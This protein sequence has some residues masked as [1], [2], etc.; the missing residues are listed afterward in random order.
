MFPLQYAPQ[1]D[2]SLPYL[3]QGTLHSTPGL[4]AQDSIDPSFNLFAL[5]DGT[6]PY[7]PHLGPDYFI[8][9]PAATQP[10]GHL[11]YQIRGVGLKT[12]RKQYPPTKSTMNHKPGTSS[13]IWDASTSSSGGARDSPAM[14]TQQMP[15]P[16]LPP[17]GI[18][19]HSWLPMMNKQPQGPSWLSPPESQEQAQEQAQAP[20]MMPPPM[21]NDEHLPRSMYFEAAT[22]SPPA[23]SQP[24]PSPSPQPPKIPRTRSWYD[25][26]LRMRVKIDPAVMNALEIARDS[27]EGAS[28]VEIKG[29]LNAAVEKVEAKIRAAPDSYIMTMNEFS[30]VNWFQNLGRFDGDRVITMAVV[31]FWESWWGDSAVF[32]LPPGVPVPEG[33]DIKN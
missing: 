23:Q 4:D 17:A 13:P 31:R 14:K 11:L 20:P 28:N 27:A 8:P 33:V 15:I 9:L 24:L 3:D 30:V 16:V 2:F 19:S 10:D 7:I 18:S 25:L 12:S 21:L 29:I 32:P 26:Q 6:G 5:A 22:I 1:F